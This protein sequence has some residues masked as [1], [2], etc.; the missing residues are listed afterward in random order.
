M[1]KLLATASILSAVVATGTLAHAADV[2]VAPAYPQPPVAYQ[3]V[4]PRDGIR[5]GYLDCGIDGGL[6]YVLGS[7]KS[8]DCVFRSAL[9]AEPVDAYSGTIR[10][11]GVDLGFTTGQRM[12]WAVVAP[13]AGYHQGSLGGLYK[14]VTAEAT[15]GAGVGANVLVGGTSGSVQLQTVSVTGQLGLNLAAAGTSM[16]LNAVN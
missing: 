12:I 9:G 4:G 11:L 7:A 1:N 15:L 16:T 5:I 6:G 14:G 8:V 10:K 2:A 3:E 13:T